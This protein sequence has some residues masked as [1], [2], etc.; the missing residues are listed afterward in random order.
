MWNE[1][2]EVPVF[3]EKSD[4]VQMRLWDYDRFSTDDFLGEVSSNPKACTLN[5][6]PCT[7]QVCLSIADV[8]TLNPKP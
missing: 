1:Y 8:A 2:L 7:L 5:P 4:Q 3:D 6:K